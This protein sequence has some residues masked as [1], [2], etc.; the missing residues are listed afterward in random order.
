MK[1]VVCFWLVTF[2]GQ[3]CWDVSEGG[4]VVKKHTRRGFGRETPSGQTSGWFNGF[5]LQYVS[6][7]LKTYVGTYTR[8]TCILPSTWYVYTSSYIYAYVFCMSSWRWCKMIWCTALCSRDILVLKTM[9]VSFAW[10]PPRRKAITT[11]LLLMYN[12]SNQ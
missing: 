2:C 8:K 9:A 12:A 1:F 6:V 11:Q 5:Q 3:Q 7:Q 10:F 4:L